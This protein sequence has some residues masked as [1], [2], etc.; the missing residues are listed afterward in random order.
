M[1]VY[2]LSPQMDSA[3]MD[4]TSCELTIFLKIATVL[5]MCRLFSSLLLPEQY[6]TRYFV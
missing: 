1:Y 3:S 5:N 6:S 4:S 2:T